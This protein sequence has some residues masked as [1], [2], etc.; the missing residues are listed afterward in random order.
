MFP[1]GSASAQ[2]FLHTRRT[3][4]S[5]GHLF[6]S[7]ESHRGH[8]EYT[9]WYTAWRPPVY[10][11]NVSQRAAWGTA[12]VN[13]GQQRVSQK[14]A[15]RTGPRQIAPMISLARHN[16]RFKSCSLLAVMWSGAQ[17]YDMMATAHNYVDSFVC[18]R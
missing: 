8:G 6:W 7:G 10:D 12:Q 4:I 5:D 15:R 16:N 13:Y 18:E 9:N 11:V 14:K 1:V 17:W 3:W 2:L